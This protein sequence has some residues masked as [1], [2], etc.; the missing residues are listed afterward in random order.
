MQHYRNKTVG[1]RITLNCRQVSRETSVGD[2]Q[3]YLLLRVLATSERHSKATQQF[4]AV[5]VLC[6][7][8]YVTMSAL[9]GSACNDEMNK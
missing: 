9:F 1:K 3:I 5:I 2:P 8:H 6:S 4:C 7:T